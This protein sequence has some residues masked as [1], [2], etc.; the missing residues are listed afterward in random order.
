VKSVSVKSFLLFSLVASLGVNSAQSQTLFA[1]S[2]T[3][4]ASGN[5][6]VGIGTA[7]PAQKLT[8]QGGHGDTRLTLFSD[9]FLQGVDGPNTAL[10]SL[11]AS[12]PGVTWGGVGIGNNIIVP[13]G[14]T[15]ITNSRGGSYIRLLDNTIGLSVVDENGTH[16]NGV[17][18]NSAGNTQVGGDLILGGNPGGGNKLL[19]TSGSDIH[20]IRAYAWWTEFV[21][22]PNEGW[23]FISHSGNGSYEERVRIM[24][25]SG[26]VGI[27]TTNPTQ[28]LD[29]NGAIAF[30]TGGVWSAGTIYSDSNWGVI[31]RAKH[32]APGIA[33]F[34]FA[35]AEGVERLRVNPSGN[36]GIGNV[37][38]GS[39][40]LAVNGTIKAKE[41]IVETTGWAD[42]VFAE[43]YTLTSLT[44]VEAHIKEHKHLPGIPSAAQVAEQ[45]VSIG[46]MQ[47]RLLAKI[48]EL[49]LHQIEQQKMLYAQT[50]VIELQSKRIEDLEG[51][52]K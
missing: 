7:F 33:E 4:G 42:Y 2:S 24:A 47:A 46:D 52:F 14:I 30:G 49:T 15:R 16:R 12:E 10:L 21:S 34:M 50:K 22:H 23:K 17:V 6:N 19:L 18:I 44:E 9:N 20:F 38:P 5:G 1:P 35:N 11:W 13:N 36:V 51:R 43:D 25:G 8:V 48:E 45:G 40:K 37:D 3:V 29:V 31:L 41:I 26:N 32:A 39:N 27:G 28:R